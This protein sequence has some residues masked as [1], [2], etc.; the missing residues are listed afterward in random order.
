[1]GTLKLEFADGEVLEYQLTRSARRRSIGLKIDHS[2]LT[3]IIPARAT[4]ADAERAIRAKI[5]WIRGHLARLKNAPPTAPRQLLNGS[6][7]QWLGQPCLI[8]APAPRSNVTDN[9]LA[10][11][12]K[13]ET[14]EAIRDAFI[15]FSRA[16]ARIYF[17]QRAAHFAPR[18]QVNPRRILLTS[19]S[20]RWGS[21]TAAG[22]VRIHWR[23]MQAPPAVI[24]YVIVHE[25]AHL[26]EMNHS[27]R[28]WAEV[29]KVIPDW[30]TYRQWL[31]Q[32]GAALHG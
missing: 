32:Y 19:A 10:L 31:R 17:S 4:V 16:T 25:L 23:L 26:K 27:P 6:A 9:V 2:G 13:I 29:E 24:D 8:T 20:T 5:T 28:F 14:P 3:L 15:R 7:V 21:C 12:S 1:M 11:A 30:K 22:D 18:M